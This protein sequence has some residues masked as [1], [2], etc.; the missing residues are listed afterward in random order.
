MMEPWRIENVVTVVAT[1]CLILG[2]YHMSHSFHA[3]WGAL[4]L[5][6]INY[7]PRK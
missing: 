2:L 5:I 1:V 6:N 4:L 3:L 7:V